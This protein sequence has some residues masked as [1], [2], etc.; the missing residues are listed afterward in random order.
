MLAARGLVGAGDSDKLLL[1]VLG[2]KFTFPEAD[3]AIGS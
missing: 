2:G 1:R 3:I